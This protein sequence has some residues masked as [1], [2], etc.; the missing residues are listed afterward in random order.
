MGRMEILIGGYGGQGILLAGWIIGN[1]AVRKGY[2]VTYLPSYGPE[3]RGGKCA[4][5]VVI[6]AED[7]IDYPLVRSLDCLIVMYQE[8]YSAYI[9]LLKPGGIL[10]VDEDLVHL[11]N[12]SKKAEVY[13]VPATRIAE[14]LGARIV[15]NIVMIGAF[16]AITKLVDKDTM[17]ESVIEGIRGRYVELNMKAFEEGYNYGLKLASKRKAKKQKA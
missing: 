16:V 1:A 5:R 7:E 3:A 6:D 14:Q 13:K 2:N 17:K 10:I 8:A 9:G 11:D 4:S 12:K 15:A